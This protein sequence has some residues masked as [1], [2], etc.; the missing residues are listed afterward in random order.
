M[1]L[2]SPI[3]L[4]QRLAAIDVDPVVGS[5]VVC[6]IP[7][8]ESSRVHILA[9]TDC[10][11]VD[12]SFTIADHGIPE[13]T[14]ISFV[15]SD[16]PSGITSDKMYWCEVVDKDT[17]KAYHDGP[18]GTADTFTDQGTGD[19]YLRVHDWPKFVWITNFGAN[20]CVVAPCYDVSY[21]ISDTD[22]HP[23]ISPDSAVP[24]ILDVMGVK[25]LAF[26]ALGGATDVHVSPLENY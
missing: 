8:V 1:M 16:L 19:H 9:P 13:G 24:F 18:G 6:G 14:P 10:T 20:P 11:V 4:T 12:N 17:I 2:K 3:K 15:G 7:G 22:E 23:V 25:A 5:T 26:E 21:T